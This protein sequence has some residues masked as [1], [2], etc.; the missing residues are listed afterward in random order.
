MFEDNRLN[1]IESVWF[2]QCQNK[3]CGARMHKGISGYDPNR[4]AKVQEFL[5]QWNRRAQ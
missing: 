5:E 4:S 2:I 1:G 3:N